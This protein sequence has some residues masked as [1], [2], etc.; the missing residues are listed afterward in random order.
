MNFGHPAYV[1]FDHLQNF[2]FK[3][4]RSEMSSLAEQLK[5]IRPT[6][7]PGT[8]G[9]G[10][11][12]KS[13]PSLLFT[14]SEAADHDIEAIFSIG[15]SGLAEL[16]KL[17]PT[18][19]KFEKTLFIRASTEFRR[20]SQTPDIIRVSDI[21]YF[22]LLKLQYEQVC[23]SSGAGFIDTKSSPCTLPFF[24]IASDNKSS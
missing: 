11:G 3:I 22:L 2:V 14:P 7:T 9:E 24:S 21:S 12:L 1:N 20:E 23:F 8:R 4:F 6:K 15:I 16:C 18:L 5:A 10:G 19:N 13:R 17:D